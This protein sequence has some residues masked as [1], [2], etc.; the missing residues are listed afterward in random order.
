MDEMSWETQPKQENFI[1]AYVLFSL[2][3]IDLF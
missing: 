3:Q 1:G 2:I